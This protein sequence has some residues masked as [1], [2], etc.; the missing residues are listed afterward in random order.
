MPLDEVVRASIERIEN[1]DG[2]LGTIIVRDDGTSEHSKIDPTDS[3]RY[4]TQFRMLIELAQSAVREIDPADDL[5]FMRV[6]MGKLEVMA[7]K[8]ID[9]MAIVLQNLK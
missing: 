3:Q 5:Q 2:V 8:E 4:V 6:Q 7:A 9:F 1:T